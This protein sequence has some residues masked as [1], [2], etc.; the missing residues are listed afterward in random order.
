MVDVFGGPCRGRTYGPLIKSAKW[1][2]LTTLAIATVSPFIVENHGLAVVLLILLLLL[3]SVV[4]EEFEHKISTGNGVNPSIETV[5][6]EHT[7]WMN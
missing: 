2:F 6:H 4:C 3:N 1:P 7:R 5:W